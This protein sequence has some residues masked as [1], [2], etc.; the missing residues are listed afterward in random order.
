M[1]ARNIV[2]SRS[3]AHRVCEQEKRLSASCTVGVVCPFSRD[4]DCSRE[5]AM[6]YFTHSCYYQAG[7]ERRGA[8]AGAGGASRGSVPLAPR[9]M[10]A[11]SQICGAASPSAQAAACADCSSTT[12]AARPRPLPLPSPSLSPSPLF[13]K[14]WRLDLI[15][16]SILLTVDR[17]M[18][19]IH[20][21]DVS[22]LHKPHRT[23]SSKR[24]PL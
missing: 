22:W 14:Q 15:N 3:P 10:M 21:V 19:S 24:K 7:E 6:D 8:G 9:E 5:R 2:R 13:S 17:D 18:E 20:G 12:P 4:V 1:G 23:P 16:N 11:Q